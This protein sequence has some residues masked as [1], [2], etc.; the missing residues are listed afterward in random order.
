MNIHFILHGLR[1]LVALLCTSSF[2]VAQNPSHQR[3]WPPADTLNRARLHT[4]IATSSMGYI[5]ATVAFNALWYSDYP[6]VKF[7]L[8]DDWILWEQ[9]DKYGHAYSGYQLARAGFHTFRWSGV[10]PGK[11]TLIGAGAATALL[12]TMEIM[13]GFSEGWGFSLYDIGFNT[14][15]SALFCSQ[16]WAWQEQRIGLK[17]SAS[18]PKYSTE[19]I[20]T[21]DPFFSGSQKYAADGLYGK[22]IWEYIFKDYNA[23]TVWVNVSPMAMLA[24]RRKQTFWHALCLSF[25]L[26][27]ENVYGAL[28][29]NYT[30]PYGR[31]VSINLP[32]YQQFYLSV[33]LD[34]DKIPTKNPLLKSLLRAINLFRIPAPALEWNTQGAFRFHPFKW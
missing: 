2:L 19:P 22:H 24:P 23:M 33:D 20:A 28:Y 3:F 7:H 9:M 32:R 10:P 11:S 16:Q 21:G 12:T 6:Q 8:K 29:N 4:L 27:A 30:D 15:G 14:L 1:I 17:L 25:G 31:V 26:G 13:D 5:G 18:R 34:L